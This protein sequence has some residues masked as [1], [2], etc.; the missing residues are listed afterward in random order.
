MATITR[1]R[2][3][4]MA[5]NK[6]KPTGASVDDYT[7]SRASEQQHADCRKLMT[8]LERVTHQ[9]PTMWGP[10]IVGYG[11]YRYTDESGRTQ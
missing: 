4:Y 6:T 2:I 11:M 5:E 10:S 1:S 3:A 7:A 8:L 9:R